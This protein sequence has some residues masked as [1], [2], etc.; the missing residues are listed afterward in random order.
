MEGGGRAE[1]DTRAAWTCHHGPLACQFHE[2]T[3]TTL[4]SHRVT[5]SF[6]GVRSS[7]YPLKNRHVGRPPGDNFVSNEV[8]S[9]RS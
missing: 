8:D 6:E 5:K 1:S 9:S 4:W 2:A 7:C 3:H